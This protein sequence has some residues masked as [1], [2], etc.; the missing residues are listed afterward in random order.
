MNGTRPRLAV[1]GGPDIGLRLRLVQELGRRF[2]VCV[3]GSD[4][5]AAPIFRRSDVEYRH[6]PLARRLSPG[7][8]L[9]TVAALHRQ[10]R[11]LKPEVVHT[12]DTKPSALGRL[13]AKMARV[14]VIVGTLPGLGSL[15]LTETVPTRAIRFIYE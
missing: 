10:F 4:R 14:P 1:V 5:D 7:R 8:D 2:D 13:A 12:Y 15:Y 9:L 11:S 6:Y 3:L